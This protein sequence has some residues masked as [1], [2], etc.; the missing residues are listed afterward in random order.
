[1]RFRY[2]SL[3][4]AT[5]TCLAAP[6]E[7]GFTPLFDGRTLAGWESHEGFSAARKETRGC[8]WWVTDGCLV[9][10][11][12]AAGGGGFL[13]VN[14]NFRDFVFRTQVK[15][16][17]PIDSGVFVRCGPTGRSHQVML[18]YLPT[19]YIG[20]IYIPFQGLVHPCPEG[21]RNWRGT[22]WNDLEIRIEGE[23]A[24]IRV[25]LNGKLITDF[26]HTTESTKGAPARGGIA[27]QVHPYKGTDIPKSAGNTA[28]Y[29]NIRI[30]ELDSRAG[31]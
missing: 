19:P 23:P 11:P 9:G 5:T 27:L 30:K 2:L 26:Q 7:N 18:D 14:R 25:W 12:D 10:A 8:K 4:V 21:V 24:R 29:R 6:D 28:R 22:E 16:D 13:W 31:T 17:Y 1:M 20:A 3:V 15:L